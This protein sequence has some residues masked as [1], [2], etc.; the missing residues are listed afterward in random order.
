MILL[1]LNKSKHSL[2]TLFLFAILLIPVCCLCQNGDDR[3]SI[4]VNTNTLEIFAN[5]E[6]NYSN[7]KVIQNRGFG[8]EI[9][10][11]HGLFLF[12][13][14][15]ISLGAGIAFN[16]NK[17]YKTL[18][19]VGDVKWY[20]SEYGENSPYV[21]LNAGRNLRIE[22]FKGGGTAKFGVGYAF[23]SD[24]GFQ[25]IMEFYIKSKEITLNQETNYNYHVSSLGISLG[26]KL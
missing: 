19:I 4:Y 16:I 1:S 9:S 10:S 5:R 11:F 7:E 14:L 3:K 18:P 8:I 2:R 21:L 13:T 15:S 17:N 26:V 20:F 25:Y 22:N 23:E 24:Y 6:S 12:R